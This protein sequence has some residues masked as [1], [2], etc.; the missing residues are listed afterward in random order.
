MRSVSKYMTV[1]AV[2][3]ML[4]ACASYVPVRVQDAETGQALAG[5]SVKTSYMTGELDSPPGKV[6]NV[7]ATRRADAGAARSILNHLLG[8]RFTSSRIRRAEALGIRFPF[9]QDCTSTV[10]T[11]IILAKTA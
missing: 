9:S 2:G 5:A 8:S 1:L 3:G 4:A 7:Q 11:P 10:D 6:S